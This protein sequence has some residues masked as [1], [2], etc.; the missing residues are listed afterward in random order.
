M[1]E[2]PTDEINSEP[3]QHPTQPLPSKEIVEPPKNPTASI[4]ADQADEE[5]PLNSL[6]VSQAAIKVQENTK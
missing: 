6:H 3:V 1:K 5:D 2:T 4:W